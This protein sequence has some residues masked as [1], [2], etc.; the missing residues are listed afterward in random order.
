MLRYKRFTYAEQLRTRIEKAA[1]IDGIHCT[2]SVGAS[3]IEK[4]DANRETFNRLIK[5]ADKCMYKAKND[6]KN[7]VVSCLVE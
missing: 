5:M 1:F 7:M 2:I 4:F 3:Y 6:G